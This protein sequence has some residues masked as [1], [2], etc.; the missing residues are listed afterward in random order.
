MTDPAGGPYPSFQVCHCTG[1]RRAAVLAAIA[2][3]CRTVDELRRATGACTGC[4]TCYPELRQL[5]REVAARPPGD[6]AG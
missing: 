4:S 2:G 1:V 6:P 3:G 5:L